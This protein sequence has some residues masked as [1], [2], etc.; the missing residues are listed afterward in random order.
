MQEFEVRRIRSNVE[1]GYAWVTLWYINEDGKSSPLH[2]TCESEAPSGSPTKFNSV[3]MERNDQAVACYGGVKQIRISENRIE[4]QLNRTGVK[5]LDLEP[6][7]VFQVPS[8]LAGWKK[9]CRI[10][11][12]MATLPPG[13]TI[14]IDL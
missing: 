12:K 10:F 13:R 6:S 4:V 2:I 11:E 3:Y 8:G 14:K 5:A 1:E 9:A 7:V